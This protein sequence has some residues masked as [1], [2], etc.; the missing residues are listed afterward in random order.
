MKMNRK[1]IKIKLFFAIT[2][3]LSLISLVSAE[4][5]S[6]WSDLVKI[7]K[8]TN[9]Y[10]IIGKDVDVETVIEL[11]VS[12]EVRGRN[13]FII[14]FDPW[15]PIYSPP[16]EN[17]SFGICIGR[18]SSSSYNDISVSCE[19]NISS[20]K[21]NE[22]IGG[23]RNHYCIV[24]K[25]GKIVCFSGLEYKDYK[26]VFETDK[27]NMPERYVIKIHY[28]MRNKTLERGNYDIFKTFFGNM[29]EMNVKNYIVLPSPFSVPEKIFP[30]NTDFEIEDVAFKPVIIFDGTKEVY[31]WYTNTE[32]IEQKE[33]RRERIYLIISVIVGTV[34]G[35][36][37][38]IITDIY[39]KRLKI[40]LKLLLR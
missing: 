7:E 23:F 14:R 22:D 28:I 30:T 12:E 16:I 9:S 17:V 34:L 20:Y 37:I 21:I 18:M 19:K 2:L 6:S 31:F 10:E 40:Y 38:S 32:E 26:I 27:I 33:N 13:D 29:G 25:K 4:E 11:F 3:F 24:N 5:I 35:W 1:N 15:E 39:K 8:I 36:I